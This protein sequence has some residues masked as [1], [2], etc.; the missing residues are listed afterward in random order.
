[1][2]LYIREGAG[3]E[4]A[5]TASG[6]GASHRDRISERY[7]CDA[8]GNRAQRLSS[9]PRR[10]ENFQALARKGY[11]KSFPASRVSRLLQEEGRITALV[12]LSRR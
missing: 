9:V 6:R 7:A 8:C 2:N 3:P 11:L 1:M 4:S 12:G 10:R 5:L